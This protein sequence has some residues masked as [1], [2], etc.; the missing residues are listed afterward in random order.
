MVKDLRREVRR[1]LA[2]GAM[3]VEGVRIDRAVFDVTID[4]RAELV[5]VAL[6]NGELVCT[7]TDGQPDGPHAM[8]ALRLLA[9]QSLAGTTKVIAS[10]GAY[11]LMGDVAEDA[12]ARDPEGPRVTPAG[13]LARVRPELSL[14]P[15]GM[16]TLSTSERPSSVARESLA[17]VLEDLV[18]AIVRLGLRNA[19]GSPSLEE[20]F[21]RLAGVAPQPLPLGIARFIG[22]LRGALATNDVDQLAELLDGAVRLAGDLR[23]A[24]PSEEGRRRIVGWLGPTADQ[25]EDIESL[26]DR[27]FVEVGREWVTGVERASIERRYLVELGSGE[28]FREERPRLLPG[29]SVG[30][31][32]RQLHVGLAEAAEGPPPRRIRLLQYTLSDTIR[33]ETFARL[34]ELS[35]RSHRALLDSYVHAIGDYPGLVE[36][37]VLVGPA[38]A[39]G[40]AI[41]LANVDDEGWPLPIVRADEGEAEWLDRLAMERPIVGIAGRLID[42]TRTLL[43]VPVS[44]LVQDEEGLRLVRVR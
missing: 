5:T 13:P 17:E 39:T 31:C 26:T 29:I 44:V 25:P 14:P 7:S 23:R 19:Q 28:I 12:I 30:P 41:A 9:G 36:P 34:E 18:T 40:E 22:R 10:P 42:V 3:G 21:E 20:A 35:V 8:A 1:R 6:R 24:H 16:R 38:R 4:G 27:T 43:L 33:P 11:A 37:F 15:A 32:P 2:S